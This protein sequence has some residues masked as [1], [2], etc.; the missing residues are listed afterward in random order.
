MAAR[1]TVTVGY[2]VLGGD[3]AQH[4][5]DMMSCV[6][7]KETFGTH[8]V[9]DSDR[10]GVRFELFCPQGSCYVAHNAHE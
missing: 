10:G 4:S 5:V 2:A 6:G 8:H 9:Q 3:G 1:N 7:A